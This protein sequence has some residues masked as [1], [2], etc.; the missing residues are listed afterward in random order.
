MRIEY[1]IPIKRNRTPEARANYAGERD[2]LKKR[3]PEFS[4]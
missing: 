4:N 1:G 3:T 2:N